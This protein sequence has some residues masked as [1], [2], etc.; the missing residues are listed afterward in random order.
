MSGSCPVTAQTRGTDGK[1]GPSQRERAGESE[2][3]TR[4][5]APDG[6]APPCHLCSQTN[7]IG[8]TWILNMLPP[9]VKTLLLLFL[10]TQGLF[11]RETTSQGRQVSSCS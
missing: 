8:H 3:E 1:S 11:Y 4:G 5:G 7:R 2:E 9:D 6:P 10:Q